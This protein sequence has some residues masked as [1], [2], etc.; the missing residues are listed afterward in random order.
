MKRADLQEEN[1]GRS[2][3]QRNWSR[4]CRHKA[5]L[6][7]VEESDRRDAEKAQAIWM[8]TMLANKTTMNSRAK[9][10]EKEQQET[11]SIR[12][13]SKWRESLTKDARH[14]E[15]CMCSWLSYLVSIARLQ[16]CTGPETW[17]SLSSSD[18]LARIIW[19]SPG[20][21]FLRWFWYCLA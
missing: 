4:S 16:P 9:K 13:K 19:K 11:F 10:R 17:T 14:T 20:N 8:E 1:R 6:L 21:W 12:N 5:T 18:T 2:T 7:W 3:T 15:E